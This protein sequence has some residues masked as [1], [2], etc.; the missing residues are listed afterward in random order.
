MTVTT[1]DNWTVS[2]ADQTIMDSL[3]TSFWPGCI[4]HG[5]S[6]ACT[7]VRDAAP[8]S[9]AFRYCPNAPD[10]TTAAA[11]CDTPNADVQAESNMLKWRV[12]SALW[13]LAALSGAMPQGMFNI[14][15]PAI[16]T[17]DGTQSN[18]VGAW[19]A[20]QMQSQP[21]AGQWKLAPRTASSSADYCSVTPPAVVTM[22]T[23]YDIDP[24]FTHFT[25]NALQ[26]IPSWYL[27]LYTAPIQSGLKHALTNNSQVLWPNCLNNPADLGARFQCLDGRNHDGDRQVQPHPVSFASLLTA[28]LEGMRCISPWGSPGGVG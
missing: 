28:D 5:T 7:K 15:V 24:A 23:A 6:G 13:T 8:F 27:T 17:L 2:Y 20:G 14:P 19:Y 3:N 9:T 4:L 1:Q 16:G 10:V 18:F 26:E 11:G 21:T 22:G 25:A 12:A